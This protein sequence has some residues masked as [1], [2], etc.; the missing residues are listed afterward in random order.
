M[1]PLINAVTKVATSPS[2]KMFTSKG[3]QMAA[4]SGK[5]YMSRAAMVAKKAFD[6]GLTAVKG[7]GST[8]LYSRE[9]IKDTYELTKSGA[10]PFR[11]FFNKK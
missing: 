9:Q 5:P 10:K 3:I 2:V 4:K 7:K 1:G 11:G 6:T 8:K